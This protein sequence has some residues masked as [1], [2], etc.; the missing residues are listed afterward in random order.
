MAKCVCVC[1]FAYVFF[2]TRVNVHET[3]II[4]AVDNDTNYDSVIGL[5]ITMIP[6]SDT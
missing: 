1:L 4:H 5:L 2:L 6:N 3:H